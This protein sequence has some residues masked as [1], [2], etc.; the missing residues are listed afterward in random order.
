[1][2]KRI[3]FGI[4]S[5]AFF[6]FFFEILKFIWDRFVPFNTLTD[7]ISLFILIIINIPLSVIC[8]QKVIKIIKQEHE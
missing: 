8:T 6:V 5:I 1:M 2:A 3:V 7:I 4:I